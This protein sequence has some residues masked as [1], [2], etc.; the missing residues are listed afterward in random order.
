MELLTRS[1][2]STNQMNIA[3]SG[4]QRP[5]LADTTR[6]STAEG[7]R[8]RRFLDFLEPIRHQLYRYARRA[9][10][11]E[12]DVPDIIQQAVMTAWR[13]FKSFEDGPNFRAWMFQILVNTTFSFNKR[14]QR[15]RDI[16]LGEI[17][18]DPLGAFELETA[19]SKVLEPPDMLAGLI[20]GRIVCSLERLNE[21]ER[22]CFLLKLLEEFRYKEIA[23]MLTTPIGTVMSHVHRARMKLREDL[24]ALAVERGLVRESVS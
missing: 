15:R 17:E 5:A 20:D 24:A 14:V 10:W 12:S 18:F 16:P 1:N 13:K 22:Q 2:V 9:A 6:C 21:V 8:S 7:T 11:R 19:W 23:V 4:T 3:A